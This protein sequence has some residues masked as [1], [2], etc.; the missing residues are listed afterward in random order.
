MALSYTLT[1]IDTARFYLDFAFSNSVMSHVIIYIS[2][3]TNAF[4][5]KVVRLTATI[6]E[7]QGNTVHRKSCWAETWEKSFESL[8]R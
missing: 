1:S 3:E 7:A 6:M 4:P 8:Q 2:F 5:S